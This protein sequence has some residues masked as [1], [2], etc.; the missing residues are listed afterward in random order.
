VGQFEY[1]PHSVMAHLAAYLDNGGNLFAASHEFATHRVRLSNGQLTTYRYD[2]QAEDPYDLNP[3]LPKELI[4]GVGMTNPASFYETEII[5]QTVWA[6]HDVTTPTGIPIYDHAD[7]RW[8]WE[9][10]SFQLGTELPALITQFST[11]N[12]VRFNNSGRPF[13]TEFEHSRT[14]PAT[15]VWAAAPGNDARAWWQA[16]GRHYS[17]WPIID[18]GYTTATFQQRASGARVVTLPTEWPVVTLADDPRYR[19]LLLNVVQRLVSRQ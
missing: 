6:G 12:L 2:S 11:G 15:I 16:N 8:I 18:Y 19:Q 13:L 5:G 3:S 17:E 1:I 7:A 14:D 4:A 9:G 10:T